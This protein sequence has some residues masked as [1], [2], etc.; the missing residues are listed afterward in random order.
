MLKGNGERKSKKNKEKQQR[1]TERSQ[2]SKLMV[3][4]TRCVSKW[5]DYEW[6]IF[7]HKYNGGGSYSLLHLVYF[8]L[9]TID[10]C[11]NLSTCKISSKIIDWKSNWCIEPNAANRCE[12]V[13]TTR[14][15][16][17]FH[18]QNEIWYIQPPLLP[19]ILNSIIYLAN[20]SIYMLYVCSHIYI[21][22]Y[23]IFILHNP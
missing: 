23:I 5:T 13:T 17:K 16:L 9:Q 11:P 14:T 19:Y 8:Y 6:T 10:V 12:R 18:F 7:W 1:R 20:V 4:M 22:I 15:D 21:Y 2:R 3:I